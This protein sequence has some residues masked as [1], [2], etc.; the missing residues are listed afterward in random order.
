ML[1]KYSDFF[2]LSPVHLKIDTYS[3]KIMLNNNFNSLTL[4][5]SQNPYNQRLNKKQAL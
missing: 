1:F 2:Q 4:W 5:N 3:L